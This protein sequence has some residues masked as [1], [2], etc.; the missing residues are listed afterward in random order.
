MKKFICSFYQTLYYFAFQNGRKYLVGNETITI[1]K[2]AIRTML[3][4]STHPYSDRK[5]LDEKFVQILLMSCVPKEELAMGQANQPAMIFIEGKQN[6]M[7]SLNFNLNS[8]KR[9]KKSRLIVVFMLH[10]N[11]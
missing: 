5:D 4:W 9:N 2:P 7:C 6:V 8:L 10:F 11:L 3:L 1:L